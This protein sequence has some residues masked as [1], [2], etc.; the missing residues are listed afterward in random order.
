MSK[1]SELGYDFGLMG[2]SI[3]DHINDNLPFF[4]ER[5]ERATAPAE[6]GEVDVSRMELMAILMLVQGGTTNMGSLAQGLAV[7]MSTA[8]GIAE[9]LEKK[10]LIKRDKDP[11][12]RRSINLELTSCGRKLVESY[13]ANVRCFVDRMKS[14]LTK[15]EYMM[16]EILARKMFAGL[17]PDSGSQ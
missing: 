1:P 12:D 5:I 8:T 11:E 3:V 17:F 7:P 16:A 6:I 4:I 2:Y 10:G 13:T 9:R 14:N 15:E